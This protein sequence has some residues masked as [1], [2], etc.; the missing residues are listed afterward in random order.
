LLSWVPGDRIAIGPTSY[1][2]DQS[3][4]NW[5]EQYDIE[6]GRVTLRNNLTYHH[7]GAAQSTANDYN[8]VDMRGEVIL[9]NRSIVIAGE[10][11]D[12]WGGQIVTSD[13]YEIMNGQ[14]NFL[15]GQ[16]ILDHV[17]IY[18][19][20][21]WDTFKSALRF[22]SAATRWSS[23][24][25]SAIHNGLGWGIRIDKS[26][27]IHLKDNVIYEFRPVGVTV[28]SSRNITI[29]GNLLMRVV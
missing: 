21:Q 28:E 13:T 18:N 19:C 7:W 16:T 12:S 6:T 24:T 2:W 25:N 23:V 1:N 20:S 15:T 3:E 11:I 4:Q 26:A 14:L 27:N 5:V 22:E 10:D 8:G 29:D 17:E 9:F